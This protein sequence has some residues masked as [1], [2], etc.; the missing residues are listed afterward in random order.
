MR[1]A[2]NRRI[3]GASGSG[4]AGAGGCSRRSLIRAGLSG[5]AVALASARAAAEP[6][7][8]PAEVRPRV[9]PAEAQYQGR[10]KGGLS[11]AACALF[12]PPGGCV[13]VRGEISPHGWCRFFDL[14]D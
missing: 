4:R 1:P 8:L 7:V 9:S 10:P 6:Q 14:P 13:V 2:P 3:A 11:C 5:A 12:R